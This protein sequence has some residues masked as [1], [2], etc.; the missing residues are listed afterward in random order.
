MA[1]IYP[2]SFNYL[3]PVAD[4]ED[5]IILAGLIAGS[6]IKVTGPEPRIIED[7]Q[8]GEVALTFVQS[9]RYEIEISHPEYISMHYTAIVRPA[10]VIID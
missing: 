8:T 1:D 4:G 5:A 2:C 6:T 3:N 7:V 9:G 10:P